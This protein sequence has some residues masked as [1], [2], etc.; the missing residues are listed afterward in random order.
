MKRI[1]LLCF[2]A[3]MAVC[4]SCR[5]K[6]NEQVSADQNKIRL[7]KEMNTV[8]LAALDKNKTVVIITGGILEQHGPYL[9]SF[10][11]GYWNEKLTDT[12][13]KAITQK[14]NRDVLIF[15]TIPLGNSGANDIGRKYSFHGTYTVRFETLRSVFMDIA[16]ELGEQGFKNVFII[17]SHGAPN[18]QRA[19]DQAT[20]FFNQV[21]QGRMVN[22]FG[23]APLQFNWFDPGKTKEQQQEDGMK[24][25]AGMQETSSMLFIQ[26][27]LVDSSYRNAKPFPGADMKQLTGIASKEGWPGYFGSPRLATAAYGEAAWNA[28]VKECLHYVFGILDNSINPDNLQRFGDAMKE[29]PEDALLDSLSLLEENRRKNIQENWLKK[30]GLK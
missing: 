3:V 16:T 27:G 23:I 29:S 6:T 4:F 9:P 19:L 8:Q 25:H 18:H 21:Y 14:T 26:P 2:F 13:A 5:P 7:L 1:C 15:P 12:L 10:T 30:M 22:L 28:N 11:D 17:H 24:M 20:E